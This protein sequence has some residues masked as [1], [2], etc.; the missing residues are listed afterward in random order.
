MEKY[1]FSGYATRNDIKCSD[2]RTIRKDAFADC[3]GKTVP[4]VWNHLHNESKNVLGHALLENR[5]DGVYTYGSFNDTKQGKDARELVKHGDIKSL[6]IYANKLSQV[7]GDVLHGEIKEVSLVL[8]GANK[9]AYIDSILV[10]GEESDDEAIIYSGEDFALYHAEEKEKEPEKEEPVKDEPA[11]KQEGKTLKEVFDTL[12]EEQKEFVYTLVGLAAKRSE[13]EDDETDDEG[14]NETMKHN[15]FDNNIENEDVY[16]THSEL[17][18]IISDGKRCG[19]LKESFLQHGITNIDYLF[20]EAKAVNNGAPEWIKREDSWVTKVMSGVHNTPFS[21]VKSTYADITEDDARAKGY[22]KGRFKK[23]QVFRLLKRTTTPQTVYKKQKLDRDDII[24]I[25]DMDV[26]SWLKTEMRMMLNE[27]L[28]RAYLVGDGRDDAS[29]D[30]INELNIRPIWTDEGFYTIKKVVNVTSGM[31]DDQKGKAFIRALI[32]ARKDYKGSG[33]PTFFTTED[34]LT[35]M[36]LIEDLNGR[37]IYEDEAK[38]AKAIRA[39]EIVTV[40]VMEGL[41]REVS[42]VEHNLVGILVNLNDY[43]VGADKGG[44]VNMFDDFDIDYN[45]QKYLIETRCSG[46]LIKPFSAIALEY[47]EGDTAPADEPKYVSTVGHDTPQVATD[48][49]LKRWA[50]YKEEEDGSGE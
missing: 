26:V 16:L 10:H 11:K 22:I 49:E 37:V 33:N 17:E 7:G 28:A 25:T 35:D 31:T 34:V 3:D 30:K 14:E 48:A 8:A 36:L 27:E 13:K 38:L 47:I 6:S 12:N 45:A 1:D 41:K 5:A 19:S 44:A 39:K 42:G 4:L 18:E 20:P 43:N 50:P 23:E 24:D 21:R 2:G 40:P 32:K 46:A 9:G 29:D 15:A